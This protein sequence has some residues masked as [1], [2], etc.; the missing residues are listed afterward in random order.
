MLLR[1]TALISVLLIMGCGGSKNVGEGSPTKPKKK[2]AFPKVEAGT[3]REKVARSEQPS[4]KSLRPAPG[5]EE[6]TPLDQGEDIFRRMTLEEIN[7]LPPVE[8]S[9]CRAFA[10]P[11]PRTIKQCRFIGPFQGELETGGK[12]ALFDRL[13]DAM[14]ACAADVSCMGVSSDWYTG[15][16][17]FPVGTSTA[18]TPDENSY[19]CSFVIHCE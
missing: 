11:K 5:L 14:G 10:T 1:L 16:P 19:G 3:A 4:E 13:E 18:F 15:A 7:G 2:T 6:R 8:D 17:W 9:I 12:S